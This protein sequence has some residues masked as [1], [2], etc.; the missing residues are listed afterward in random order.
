MFNTLHVLQQVDITG[1]LGRELF[2]KGIPLYRPLGQT[3]EH[4]RQ[5]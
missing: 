4:L 1:S 5:I 2:L 3:I